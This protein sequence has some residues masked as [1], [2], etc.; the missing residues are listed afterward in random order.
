MCSERRADEYCS[1]D[2]CHPRIGRSDRIVL[3]RREVL[4]LDMEFPGQRGCLAVDAQLSAYC[5]CQ[6]TSLKSLDK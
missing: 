5:Y 6:G 4:L 1:Q 3:S 2:L